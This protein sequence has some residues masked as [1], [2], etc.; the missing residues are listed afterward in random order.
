MNWREIG[1]VWRKELLDTLRDRRTIMAMI[2][3]PMLIYPIMMIGLSQLATRQMGKIRQSIAKVAIEPT[4][5]AQSLESAFRGDSSFVV[6]QRSE[7]AT[8]IDFEKVD[9]VVQVP[10][11]FSQQLSAEDT[12]SVHVRVDL[13]SDRGQE[14][15]ERTIDFLKEWRSELVHQRLRD[16]DLS[17]AFAEP[18][19][20]YVKNEA[21]ARKM[22]GSLAGRVLPLL[23]IAMMVT[24]ALYPAIDLTAGEKER[25]TL[26]TLLV[27]PV[28][29]FSVVMGKYL[30]VAVACVVTT[31]VNLLS[32]GFTL[33][34]LLGSAEFAGAV[35]VGSLFDVRAFL[36]VFL[37]MLPM[38][39]FFSG[40]AM[41]VASMARS[42]K[43]AQNL[44]SPVLIVCLAPAYV[45]LLPGVEFTYEMALTPIVNV[46]MLTRE[47]LLGNT[48]WQLYAVSFGIMTALALLMVGI[49]TRQFSGEAMLTGTDGPRLQVRALFSRDASQKEELTPAF[50]GQIFALVLLG[51]FY[52]GSPLQ[53]R[54]LHWGIALTQI[55]VLAGFP[56]AAM[57]MSRIPIRDTLRLQLSKIQ[58][59]PAAVG[60]FP[61]A[62]MLAAMAAAA[63]GK[64][65]TVPDSYRELMKN[66]IQVEAGGNLWLSLFVFA[67]LPG[68]CEEILFRGFVL[69]GLLKRFS[70]PAAIVG[71][72]VLFGVFHFDMYRLLPTTMLGL[73]LGFL[74]W[75]TGCLWPAI[76]VHIANNALAVLSLNVDALKNVPWLQEE[77][78]VP[79]EVV[80]AVIILGVVCLTVLWKVFPYPEREGSSRSQSENV[81]H[82]NVENPSQS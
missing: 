6:V 19:R 63:Q 52:I 4:G 42:F 68:I 16:H 66:L 31:I 43:E 73:V 45:T 50:V 32:I 39:L 33:Y 38:A 74:A 26:E 34:F 5:A 7:N 13:S 25:G 20:I 46:V 58:W 53:L 81:F 75:R 21:S 44:L 27:S 55:L 35:N 70:A 69:R 77:G 47:L 29:R 49:T 37:A 3:V 79:L 65:L 36:L 14:L 80:A 18:F 10:S 48:P 30:T 8:S 17:A 57:R 9:V 22:G 67:V 71:T 61:L 76:L 51:F 28:S 56:L 23:M 41:F 60:I 78:S 1:L 82:G 62:T 59:A 64:V 11:N 2:V 40:L 72:A 54:D 15:R 24:A 12:A